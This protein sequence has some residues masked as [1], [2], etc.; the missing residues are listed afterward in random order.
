MKKIGLLFIVLFLIGCT[1]PYT[2]DIL[3]INNLEIVVEIAD[4]QEEQMQGLMNRASLNEF[5]G[6]LFVFPD[7]MPRTFWMKNT[8]IPLDM[9]HNSTQ[10]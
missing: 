1:Q 3:K 9:I 5:E 4:T 8:L 7:E 2:T 10:Q 6:M